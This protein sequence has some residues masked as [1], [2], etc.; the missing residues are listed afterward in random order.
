MIGYWQPDS[1]YCR[2]PILEYVIVTAIVIYDILDDVSTTACATSET[3]FFAFYPEAF[4]VHPF[5]KWI[6]V[7]SKVYLEHPFLDINGEGNEDVI[8]MAIRVSEAMSHR[9]VNDIVYHSIHI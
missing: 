6:S 9:I 1:Y 4:F 2:F 5:W 8:I 7:V 3:S